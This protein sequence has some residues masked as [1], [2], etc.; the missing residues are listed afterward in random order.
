V[1]EIRRAASLIG[2]N[3]AVLTGAGISVAAG[4]PDFRSP[5]GMYDTLRPEL[6]TCTPEVRRLLQL[7]P[8]FVVS[9]EVFRQTPLPYL[10]VR[11]PFILGTAEQRWKPTLGHL[12]IALL[13]RKQRLKY[14]F[15]QNIDGLDYHIEIPPEL[16]LPVHGT[17]ARASCEFCSTEIPNAD[18]RELVRKNIKDI[19]KQDAEAP[20]ESTI[21]NCPSCGK[22]G[23]KPST[24]LY[25]RSLPALFFEAVAD[26][27]NV[28][29][30]IVIGTS[31]TVSPANSLPAR[32][33]A[34]CKRLLIN[35]DRISEHVPGYNEAERGNAPLTSRH[36]P[37]DRL[38]HSLRSAPER[39]R[40]G[41]RGPAIHRYPD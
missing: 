38:R 25:G 40:L 16:I 17:I 29:T 28:D 27:D 18:F 14:L 26:L 33:P 41:G 10:E 5:G 24:V 32:V 13:A 34:S 39:A 12:L 31:L 23:L 1:D 9:W 4:I 2:P 22:P 35:R 15:T 8:T 7:D 11:R 37:P 30:L 20:A 19:Y 36:V 6:I 21:F 3:V